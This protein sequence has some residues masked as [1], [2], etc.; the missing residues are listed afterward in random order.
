MMIIVIIDWVHHGSH[1]L[2]LLPL[3]IIILLFIIVIL[4]SLSLIISL[5]YII[6]SSIHSFM[7]RMVTQLG[8]SWIP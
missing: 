7:H 3:P 5:S 6:I 8:F 2:I 1:C 4:I